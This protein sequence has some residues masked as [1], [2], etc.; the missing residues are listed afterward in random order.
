MAKPTWKYYIENE[1]FAGAYE[2]YET[3]PTNWKRHWFDV[4]VQI[5]EIVPQKEYI[6]DLSTGEIYEKAKVPRKTYTYD[7][8]ENGVDLLDSAYQKCYLF[9]FYNEKNELVCSKIG[10][11]TRKVKQRL[12]EELKSKTY[13]NMGC[14]SAVI[15]RVYDCKDI[16]AEGLESFFR[17][18]YIRQYPN[19]FKKNDRFLEEEFDLDVADEIV[20]KYFNF[21]V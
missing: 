11:T 13:L 17:A 5:A 10:T 19:A 15:D 1:D 2:R 7:I 4:C 9:K 12:R 14:T 6:I 8:D 3:A 20:R 18:L 16:P 21:E